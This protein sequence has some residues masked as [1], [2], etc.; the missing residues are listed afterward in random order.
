MC[1][2][3]VHVQS[4][5]AISYRDAIFVDNIRPLEYHGYWP[6]LGEIH[7]NNDL[8]NMKEFST[9]QKLFTL[10]N[11]GQSAM[12]RHNSLITP[13]PFISGGLLSSQDQYLFDHLH[14][15]WANCD[16]LGSEHMIEQQK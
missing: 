14:F 13:K 9:V 3:H 6:D 10:R 8:L 5:I 1:G 12:I 7:R 15:H 11:T 16:E 2:V 4:P